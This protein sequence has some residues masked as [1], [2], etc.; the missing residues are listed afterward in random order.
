MRYF[1]LEEL[2]CPHIFAKYG[3]FAWNFLDPRLLTLLD[4]IRS[5]IGK[6]VT[7]NNYR[8]GL[9]ERGLRC[10]KCEIVRKEIEAGNLYMSAHT[11]GKAVDFDVE[12]LTAE[13][14]RLI[15]TAKKNL[16]PYGFRL[17]R[18]VTWVHLDM[19]NPGIEKIV[20]FNP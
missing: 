12:G 6:P 15:L 18:D 2:V 10:T 13:E 3:G 20:F 4:N 17:E 5:G 19:F 1:K 14:T 8:D 16:W 11:L 7:V 9:D